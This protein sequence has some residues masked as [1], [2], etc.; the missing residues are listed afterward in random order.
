ML[1]NHVTLEHGLSS[2]SVLSI[3]QDHKGFLWFGTRMGVNRYDGTRFKHYLHNDKDSNTL[4]NN[5]VLSLFC[6]S[7]NTIW[8][9]TSSGL[10][11]Y[12]ETKD[13]FERIPLTTG[14]LY[15]S[16][17]YEDRKGTIWIGSSDGLYA[18]V[19]GQ[20][21]KRKI[22][23]AGNVNSIAGNNVRTLFEDHN[24]HLWVGS[25]NGLTRMV[26]QAN[27]Y[28]FENFTH[29]PAN[30]RSLSARNVTAIAEDAKQQLWI[31]TL[32]NGINLFDAAANSFTRFGKTGNSTSGLINNNIRII[33]TT[34][35]GMLWVGTQE[36]LS[37]IDPVTKNIHSYQNDPGNK[38]S[39]SQNSIHS[40]YE[41]ANGSVWIG[42]YFGGANSTYPYSTKFSVLQNNASRTSLGNNVVSS[43]VEDGQHNLWMGTEGGGLNYYNRS[44]GLFT[45]YKNDIND[46]ASLGSNLVKIVLVDKEQNIWCGTHGGGLNVLDRRQNKFKRY[47]YKENDAA[48]LH[49]EI[50]SLVEDDNERLW[51]GSNSGL[52]LFSKKGIELTP[53]SFSTINGFVNGI[54]ART[55]YNDAQGAVWIGGAPGLYV[56]NGNNMKELNDDLYINTITQDKK[57]NIWAALSYGGIAMYNSS[58]GQ[59][60]RYTEKDGLPNT[61][62]ISLLEDDNGFFWLST[63]NGLIKYDPVLKTAQTYTVSDGLAGNEF[64]YNSYL[65]DSRGEF[66]FGGYHGITS[67][68]PG[69]IET[70]SYVAPVVFTGLRLFNNNVEINGEDGLLDRN[71]NQMKRIVFTHKQNVFTIEF[72][73]LNFI[74]SNKNQYAYKL[75]GFDKNWNKVTTASATYTNLPSGTYTFVVKAANNDG[76]WSQPASIELKILPPFWLTWWAYCIYILAFAAILF[77]VIRFF[78]L[79]ALLKKEDE[80]HQV[81]LNF[82]TNVSHEIRTHLTLI[83]APVD[84]LLDKKQ[85]D[86]FVQQQLTQVKTNANRLLKLVSELMDFRKAETN[87]LNLRFERHNLIPFLQDICSSFQEISAAKHIHVSF[88]HD[89]ED[90]PVYFDKEQLE[91]VFFN[92][93]ANAFKFTHEGGRISLMVERKDNRVNISV[94]DNG[95]GIAP[96][97]LDKLFTNFFQVAEHGLQNTGYGIGLA[98]SKNIVELHKGT[99]GVESEQSLNGKEGRTVFKVT[100]LQGNRHFETPNLTETNPVVKTTVIESVPV[101]AA[102]QPITTAETPREK[103][104]SILITED[105]A[106]LRSLVKETFIDQ[107]NVIACEDGLQGWNTA[108]ELIPD[109]IISDVMMPEMDG[110]TLCTKLKTDERTS[111]IPVILLTAKS[112]QDDQVNGLETGADIYITKPFSKKILELNVRNLLA[113]REKLREKFSQ[114]IIAAPETTATT[115]T[116]ADAFVNTVDK[117]FLT[118]VMQLVDEHMDDPDFGVEKLARKVAM[119]PPILYKKIKAVSNMSVNEFV[120]SLRLKK[121][122]QL[123]QQTDMTVYEVAY[124]V[125]YNDRK[126]FSREFKKQFG[127]TPSEYA[128]VNKD[129]QQ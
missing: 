26:P 36:G 56:V 126:Y 88:I 76:V 82:F 41:D 116:V 8:A 96:E 119:S 109:L 102:H 108:V 65:R 10:N 90:I 123:L 81:K 23:R 78:F 93:L 63:D 12:N 35:N 105:N 124:N 45:V 106:E 62:V 21:D 50:I 80:L 49:S 58:N 52:H 85:N 84:K 60:V 68:F 6:D 54:T 15:I 89:A 18:L 98:L 114:Q 72:A 40:L 101:E 53:L 86:G 67:F 42:T 128:G 44:T 28:R 97:Y 115:E 70:N 47:M 9:G 5:N 37:I 19:N 30:P 110:F 83:M 94:T 117:E 104:F 31:G 13:Y 4:N 57:G 32:N 125:G 66:F 64:N 25:N 79:R 34:R 51:V 122:A 59:F 71:I 92:L 112:S 39:L 73:L 129:E 16:Y 14:T 24:G 113:A 61:N 111:H 7:R 118:R 48:T 20:P 27:G 95:K 38:K 127:K 17:I 75:E 103:Q 107:Y 100:L 43:I 91:K 74:K 2:N 22:F 120:K 121:A 46:A 99:I 11:R 77:L 55:F 33:T 3:T 1:F 69:N 87:H 29:D